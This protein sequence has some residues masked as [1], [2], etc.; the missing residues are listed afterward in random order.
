MEAIKYYREKKG[1]TQTDLAEKLGI[2]KSTVSMWEIGERKPDIITLK[3]LA[4]LF[5][6]TADDLLRPIAI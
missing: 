2:A 3:K 1:W 4:A 6:C 5:D